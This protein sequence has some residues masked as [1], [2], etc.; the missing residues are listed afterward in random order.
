MLDA[1]WTNSCVIG[2]AQSMED[3]RRSAWSGLEGIIYV[4]RELKQGVSRF[5]GIQ[6]T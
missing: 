4:R 5:C 2:I 6:V 3:I 1:D